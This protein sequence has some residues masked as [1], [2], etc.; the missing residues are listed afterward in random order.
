M[1]WKD[2]PDCWVK[3]ELQEAKAGMVGDSGLYEISS[4]GLEGTMTYCH[5]GSK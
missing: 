2:H 3:D 1:L 4:E 5:S